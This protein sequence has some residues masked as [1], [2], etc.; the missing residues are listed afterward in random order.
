MILNRNA[1]YGGLVFAILLTFYSCSGSPEK[2]SAALPYQYPLDTVW[3]GIPMQKKHKLYLK[4]CLPSPVDTI[5]HYAKSA[6]EF[7]YYAGRSESEL[8][9]LVLQLKK[10]QVFNY[11]FL[12]ALGVPT[13]KE[14]REKLKFLNLTGRGLT[15]VPT[16]LGSLKNLSDLQLSDNTIRSLG[17]SLFFCRT[18]KKI[19]LSSNIVDHIPP[20]IS[21]LNNLE[22]LILRDNRLNS[23]P[24]NFSQLRN[25]KVLDLSNMHRN[26]SRGY[27]N[28]SYIPLSVCNLP[29][30]EKL[31]LEKLPIKLIPVNIVYLK[32]LKVLSLNGCYELNVYNAIRILSQITELQ[33]LDIS[34]TGTTKVPNEILLLKN[35]KVLVWQEE[36]NSNQEEI[37]RLKTL[38]PNTK[39]Y[40]GNESR[41]FLRGN[42]INTIL[43]GY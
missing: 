13:D 26:L 25:L 14:A 43:N 6:V 39:I 29:N 21:Y 20:E 11:K 7:N 3:R 15:H 27:N 4:N 32:K 33:V 36:G 38:M 1:R 35:L 8:P 9:G 41:P 19:D 42:S 28:F 22:E 18:L 24:G 16:E 10:Q 17:A 30:L 2:E 12:K 5:L 34:F 37:A 31:L 40:S 23:L